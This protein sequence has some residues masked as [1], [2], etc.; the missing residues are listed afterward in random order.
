MIIKLAIEPISAIVGGGAALLGGKA[1]KSLAGGLVS[2][3][4]HDIPHFISSKSNKLGKF[5]QR[6]ALA[7][8]IVAARKGAEGKVWA[9]RKFLPSAFFQGQEAKTIGTMETNVLAANIPKIK[10]FFKGNKLQVNKLKNILGT[11]RVVDRGSLAAQVAIPS[12][13]GISSFKHEYDRSGDIK[14]AT[15]RGL[16]GAAAGGI[17]SAGLEIPRRLAGKMSQLHKHLSKDNHYGYNLL[18][19]AAQHAE[20]SMNR[21]GPLNYSKHF[22]TTPQENLKALPGRLVG[23]N[24]KRLMG[25]KVAKRY[26]PVKGYV[27][28]EDETPGLLSRFL[29][30]ADEAKQRITKIVT[31]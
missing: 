15:R 6:S 10:H 2:H 1:L 18:E 31:K 22:Y 14:K 24:L 11:A 17:A 16:L 8:S 23:D 29:D 9:N 4:L 21:I 13:T 7:D 28:H 19:E 5:I 27:Y 20:K 26:D 25:Q 3:Q 12:Y 30:K